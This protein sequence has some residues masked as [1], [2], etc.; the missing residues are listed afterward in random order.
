MSARVAELRR[1]WNLADVPATSRMLTHFRECLA[2]GLLCLEL[3]EDH[4]AEVGGR[5]SECPAFL[6]G[7]KQVLGRLES[8][9]NTES[10]CPEVNLDIAGLRHPSSLAGR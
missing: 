7:V 3:A 4:H 10:R 9:L 5:L 2:K 1:G 6:A 8:L